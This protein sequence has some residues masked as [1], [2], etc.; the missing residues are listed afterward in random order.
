MKKWIRD[1]HDI[2]KEQCKDKTVL[3]IGCMGSGFDSTDPYIPSLSREIRSTCKKYYG[4]DLPS[5]HSRFDQEENEDVTMFWGDARSFSLPIEK[6]DVVVAGAIIEHIDNTQGF[7]NSIRQHLKDDG[8]LIITLLREVPEALKPRKIAIGAKA[9]ST[10]IEHD[11][12]PKKKGP[13]A[14]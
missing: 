13:Q 12:A 5:E 9:A 6:V 8:L 10:V 7:F 4:I 2:I 3:D 11:A 1:Y 14:A